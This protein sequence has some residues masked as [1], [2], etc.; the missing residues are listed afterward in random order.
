VTTAQCW[1][2]WQVKN[3]D[4]DQV[5]AKVKVRLQLN[6]MQSRRLLDKISDLAERARARE[7]RQ[8]FEL[9]FLKP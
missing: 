5:S 2:L 3:R 8:W 6:A 7:T 4:A 1:N 9:E